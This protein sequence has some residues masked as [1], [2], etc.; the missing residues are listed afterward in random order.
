MRNWLIT[1][2]TLIT[3]GC[4]GNS[5]PTTSPPQPDPVLKAATEAGAIVVSVQAGVNVFFAS[6]TSNVNPAD[7]AA[8]NKVFASVSQTVLN[9]INVYSTST[10]A[11]N[12]Q[13]LV[14][15]IVGGVNQIVVQFA[16][17]SPDQ[18]AQ[19]TAWVNAAI[20]II[21][22]AVPGAAGTGGGAP[23]DLLAVHP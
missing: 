21:D 18:R 7:Q 14:N 8:V 20:A 11:T 6:G 3:F 12:K 2:V 17:F 4:A 23:L 15:A 1:L 10:T 9:A 13:A 22:L 19:Y 16:K 5:K